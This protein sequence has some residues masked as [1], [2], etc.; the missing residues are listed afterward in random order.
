MSTAIGSSTDVVGFLKVQHKQV[1]KMF[2]AVL[3]AQGKDREEAFAA[4]RGMLKAHE[5]A[6]QAIVHPAARKALANGDAIVRERLEEEAGATKALAEL[7]TLEVGSGAFESK[8]R[9][10]QSKVLA[11][12]EAEET[13][14]FDALR[15]SLDPKQLASMRKEVETSAAMANVR[16]PG[17]IKMVD[18]SRDGVV[19]SR[20]DK[21]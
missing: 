20:T 11:H 2:A 9:T 19:A 16:A 17:G 10:L 3:G 6:E 7:E 5:A 1:K 15:A 14:E 12:A 8:F 18:R 4:L 13:Q 21:H